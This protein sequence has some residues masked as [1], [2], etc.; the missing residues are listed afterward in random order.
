M[1][2]DLLSTG[3]DPSSLWYIPTQVIIRQS[4]LKKDICGQTFFDLPTCLH[5][6]YGFLHAISK[7]EVIS[8]YHEV[9]FRHTLSY[10]SLQT[11]VRI[12]LTNM[13]DFYLA[14]LHNILSTTLREHHVQ[15]FSTIKLDEMSIKNLDMTIL[16]KFLTLQSNLD[17]IAEDLC[18]TLK[19]YRSLVKYW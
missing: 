7:I 10:P 15:K 18:D 14:W 9:S 3:P 12:S 16:R 4:Q 8:F 5:L 13:N 2:Q 11:D 19:A 1:V 6:F 17:P